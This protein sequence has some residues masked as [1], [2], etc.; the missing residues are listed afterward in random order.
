MKKLICL[1][2]A[3]LLISVCGLAE[4]VTIVDISAIEAA[5][6][7]TPEPEESS[8][9]VPP[10]QNAQAVGVTVEFED[11]FSLV[12]PEGWMSYEVS[13]EAAE[14]GVY[15]CLSDADGARW[16]YIQKWNTDCADIDALDALIRRTEKPQSSTVHEFNGTQFIV[17]DLAEGDVSCCAT[18]LDGCVLNF[19]FTPQ[20][21]AEYMATAVQIIGTFAIL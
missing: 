8:A 1:V 21:D 17:Y 4:D 19:V 13:D 10:V 5:P 12:F 15:Y 6:V 11:G 18:L 3:L 14:T 16:L 20:S 2:L 9:P 7:T